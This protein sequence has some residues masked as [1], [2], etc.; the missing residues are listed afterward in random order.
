MLAVWQ[1]QQAR[2]VEVEFNYSHLE[3]IGLVRAGKQCGPEFHHSQLRL[4]CFDAGRLRVEVYGKKS[5][6]H[7]TQDFVGKLRESKIHASP[8]YVQPLPDCCGH[9]KFYICPVAAATL[10]LEIADHR[11]E[12]SG[13]VPVAAIQ[14]P[15]NFDMQIHTA[16]QIMALIVAG[17]DFQMDGEVTRFSASP[18]AVIMAAGLVRSMATLMAAACDEGE[19]LTCMQVLRGQLL[20]LPG[21]LWPG[22]AVGTKRTAIDVANMYQEHRTEVKRKQD[23]CRKLTHTVK[24]LRN[25]NQSLRNMNKSL[26]DK[27]KALGA[28]VDPAPP[29]TVDSLPVDDSGEGSSEAMKDAG[30]ADPGVEEGGEEAGA[31]GEVEEGEGDAEGGV[32]GEASVEPGVEAPASEGVEK[33]GQVQGGQGQESLQEWSA[34]VY[35][36]AE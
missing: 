8:L 16:L 6:G 35:C 3:K 29:S 21:V 31:E 28:T 11:D 7:R 14:L 9:Y 10:I 4:S 15:E 17:E 24:E 27:L 12:F 33:E 2:S 19:Y 23:E 20:A 5:F 1:R 34:D 18:A 30:V 25:E 22:K 26:A 32:E 36:P 13:H